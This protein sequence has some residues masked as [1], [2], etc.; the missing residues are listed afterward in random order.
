[1]AGA[2]REAGGGVRAVFRGSVFSVQEDGKFGL[3]GGLNAVARVQTV[4]DLD[5][6]CC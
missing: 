1:M 6:C 3:V 2:L 5:A 4:Q